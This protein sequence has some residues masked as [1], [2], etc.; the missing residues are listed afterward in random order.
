MTATKWFDR[1]FDFSAIQPDF[2]GVIERLRGTPLRLQHRLKEIPADLLR[3]QVSG[4]W[5][6]LEQVGHLGDLEP[7]WQGRLQDI[8]D[9]EKFLRPADLTNRLTHEAGHNDFSPDLLL[10]H[11]RQLRHST[12]EQLAGVRPEHLSLTA[13]HPRLKTPMR[14]VDLFYFVAEHDDHHLAQISAIWQTLERDRLRS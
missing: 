9:G 1:K 8:L 4:Q 13:L 5:S 2:P 14:I 12:M 3:D 11:F 10:E 7:L 6:I